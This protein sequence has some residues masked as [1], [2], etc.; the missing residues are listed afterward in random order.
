MFG[1]LRE[2]A[3]RDSM[4]QEEYSANRGRYYLFWNCLK[5]T[6]LPVLIALMAGDAAHQ[7]EYTPDEEIIAE[8]TSQLRNVFKRE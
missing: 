7:A 2:P 1:L 3:N 8:V 6:G 4:V 5:T